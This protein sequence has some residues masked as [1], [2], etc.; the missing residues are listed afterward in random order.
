[1]EGLETSFLLHMYLAG[2][3]LSAY[4]STVPARDV[5]WN[6]GIYRLFRKTSAK[7]ALAPHG[8]S[9]TV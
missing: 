5:P 1:M 6:S 4:Q 3:L 7:A 8:K 9:S 2:V